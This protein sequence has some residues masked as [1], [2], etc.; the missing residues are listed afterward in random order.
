LVGLVVATLILGSFLLMERTPQTAYIDLP[1]EISQAKQ[2][3][4]L[5]VEKVSNDTIFLGFARNKTEYTLELLDQENVKIDNGI[6]F[7]I[8]P[9]DSIN[10]YI[11]NDNL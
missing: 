4:L 3:D 5:Q 2:G 10:S 8:I 7:R 11:Q 1:E 9:F 6:E